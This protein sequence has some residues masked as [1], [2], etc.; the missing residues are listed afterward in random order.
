MSSKTTDKSSDIWSTALA[1]LCAVSILAT[2]V[3]PFY[4]LYKN[5]KVEECL[6]GCQNGK[7]KQVVGGDWCYQW[8]AEEYPC[9]P[10]Y[11]DCFWNCEG[12]YTPGPMPE[13]DVGCEPIRLEIF[14][15]G[16][17]FS[18]KEICQEHCIDHCPSR[19][20]W[21]YTLIAASPVGIL[22]A[23]LLLIVERGKRDERE[24]KRLS[25][26]W[27]KRQEDK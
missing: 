6:E 4:T 10:A 15:A 25:E 26:E 18:T 21:K 20:S 14:C 9:N 19:L 13:Y 7:C 1:V 22:V 17:Y 11:E 3:L 24:M 23:I 27:K 5:S 8:K 12:N 2:L 16:E